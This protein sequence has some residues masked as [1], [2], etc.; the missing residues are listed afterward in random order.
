[1]IGVGNIGFQCGF[2][3]EREKE[4]VG[5]FVV[6]TLNTFR[7]SPFDRFDPFDLIFEEEKLVDDPLNVIVSGGVLEFKKYRMTK[8]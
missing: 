4:T 7:K 1:M 5:E 6:E 3:R 2:I 8:L